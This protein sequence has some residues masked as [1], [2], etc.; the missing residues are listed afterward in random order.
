MYCP[1]LERCRVV[2]RLC[3]GYSRNP[4]GLAEPGRSCSKLTGRTSQPS[5]A[6]S[7]PFQARTRPDPRSSGF[8]HGPSKS[9][10]YGIPGGSRGCI[11]PGGTLVMQVQK[12]RSW[13]E[14][15]TG[16]IFLIIPQVWFCVFSRRRNQFARRETQGIHADHAGSR[17]LPPPGSP[18]NGHPQLLPLCHCRHP[19]FA[20]G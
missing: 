5:R 16:I 10:G 13:S 3:R 1:G 7:S 4:A 18:A 9:T 17:L 12:T 11:S 15:L 8:P 14:T 2:A 19:D 6:L 20:P